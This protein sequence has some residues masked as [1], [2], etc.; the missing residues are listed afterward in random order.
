VS[1]PPKSKFIVRHRFT[2]EGRFFLEPRV[3]RGG[4][5]L[6]GET[7]GYF[8][9]WQPAVSVGVSSVDPPPPDDD[10]KAGTLRLFT[11]P[12][13]SAGE[14]VATTSTG[15]TERFRV[16]GGTWELLGTLDGFELRPLH[17]H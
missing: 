9:K 14:I 8:R 11:F 1:A 2:D 6:E 16:T 5:L 7:D 15:I 10:G 13:G 3:S 4:Y 17:L 12:R